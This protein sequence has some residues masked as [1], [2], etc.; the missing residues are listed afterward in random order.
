[1][2][3]IRDEELNVTRTVWSRKKVELSMVAKGAGAEGRNAFSTR[4]HVINLL[5]ALGSV[6]LCNFHH[7]SNEYKHYHK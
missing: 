4:E 3:M 2:V 7:I 5:T 1:M 6:H